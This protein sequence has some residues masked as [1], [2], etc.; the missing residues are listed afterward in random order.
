MIAAADYAIANGMPAEQAER[1]FTCWLAASHCFLCLN[2]YPYGTGH[3]LIVPYRHLASLADLPEPKT[4]EM[5]ALA[6]RVERPCVRSIG[7]TD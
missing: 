4:A 5:M 1:P 7:R 3:I 2:A 6:Q